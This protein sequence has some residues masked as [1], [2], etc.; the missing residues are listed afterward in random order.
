MERT[1]N[2]V[3]ASLGFAI[4][5]VALTL[6]GSELITENFLVPSPR[7][8]TGRRADPSRC[9][10]CGVGRWW[11]TSSVVESSWRVFALGWPE[12]IGAA[13]EIGERS[14]ASGLGWCPSPRP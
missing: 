2:E 10:G 13:V 4:G 6:A 1:G 14:V 3:V 11:P 5:F 8:S 9:C 12:E 7:S